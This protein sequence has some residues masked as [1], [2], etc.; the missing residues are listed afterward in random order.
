M[1]NTIMRKELYRDF[2]YLKCGNLR[3]GV[4]I[5]IPNC[6]ITKIQAMFPECDDTYLG[7]TEE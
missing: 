2:T 7:F 4:R 1:A 3:R 6:V 5:Q